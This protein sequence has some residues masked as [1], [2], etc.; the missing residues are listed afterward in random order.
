[1]LAPE[2]R[3]AGNDVHDLDVALLFAQQRPDAFQRLAHVL[4]KAVGR[5]RA[6]VVGVRVERLGISVHV[7]LKN[8][9]R[10]DTLQGAVTGFVALGQCADGGGIGFARQFQVEG[11]TFDV[12]APGIVE[13]VGAFGPGH[14]LAV[15]IQALFLSVVERIGLGQQFLDVLATLLVP[16]A[17]SI[18]NFKRNVQFVIFQKIVE[19]V[20]V[21]I[22]LRHVGSQ[23]IQLAVVDVVKVFLIDFRRERII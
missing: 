7:H 5:Y 9:L 11:L 15:S 3:A 8:L 18:V 19:R 13:F 4:L 14:F 16:L 21:L 1:M 23:E 20:L 6:E 12:L 22:E 2:S 10:A 17:E